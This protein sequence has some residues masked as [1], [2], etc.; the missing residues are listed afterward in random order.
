[1]TELANR[2]EEHTLD[3]YVQARDGRK[4]NYIYDY[5]ESIT[6]DHSNLKSIARGGI[7]YLCLD[8]N[9]T[10]HLTGAYQQP[11]HNEVIM[12]FFTIMGFTKEH[13]M[14]A[15]GEVIRRPI[16]QMDGSPHKPVLPEGLSF[17]DTLK[18]LEEV[19]INTD[20]K[21][22]KQLR[23]MLE[24]LW[25]APVLQ[26]KL[27]K[28]RQNGLKAGRE[29]NTDADSSGVSALQEPASPEDPPGS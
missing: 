14:D 22:A 9:Y 19:D 7:V 16:G 8:C 5:G 27:E 24:Q 11:W 6:C 18:A 15:L 21:G 10:F 25:E 12:A 26:A 4:R 20:D 13:G 2:E 28:R 29:T 17:L 1:M 23:V 3:F